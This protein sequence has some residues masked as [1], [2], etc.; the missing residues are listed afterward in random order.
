MNH[1]LALDAFMTH[2]K[3]EQGASL[4]TIEAYNRDILHYLIFLEESQSS[5][6]SVVPEAYLERL[7]TDGK[8]TRSIARAVSALRSFYRFLLADRQIAT[9]PLLEIETPRFKSPIP[10]V[11]SEE[12]M[13]T[14]MKLPA[15][16]KRR[17]GTQLSW[18]SSMQ[19]AF[20]SRN[21]S[22]SRRAMSILTPVSSSPPASG[23]RSGLCLSAAT[24]GK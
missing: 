15:D 21:W 16:Q 13:A 24:R 19:P 20:A 1:Y 9:N 12:E 6:E 10:R 4:H 8:S 22:P 3:T 23:Q 7:R 18:S 17:P 11:L 5:L 14:L 2:L